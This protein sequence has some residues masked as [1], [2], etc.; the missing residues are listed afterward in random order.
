MK[1]FEAPP[2]WQIQSAVPGEAW[3][4][5]LA[6]GGAAVLALLFQLDRSQ[7]L[8]LDQLRQRQLRQLEVLVRHALATVPYYRERWGADYDPAVP[9]TL[10]RFARLPLLTRRELQEQFESLKSRKVPTGHG[11]INE[12]QSSGSTGTPVRILKTQL[13]GLFWNALTLRDHAWHRRNLR[14]K[15]A[16]IRHGIAAGEF[17]HWG[18]A[19]AG[20][21]ADGPSVVLGVRDSVQTQLRWLEQ[22]QPEYLMT[23]PSIAAELAKLVV[24]GENRLPQLREVRT[25]G[26]QLTPEARELCRE[27]WAVPVTDVYSAEEVGY[28]ALQ[29]PQHEH[30]HIQEEGA[31][32]EILD[33]QDQ[34]CAPGQLGRVVVTTLHNFAMPLIRYELGD[35]AEPGEPCACGRGLAVLRRVAGRVRNMLV[36]AT[37]ERYWPAFGT[38]SF[39]RFAPVRQCQLAQIEY[40]LIEA[41]LVTAAALS[42]EQEDG[43]RGLI[44]SRLPPGFRVRFAY[45]DEIARSAGG[46]YEDFVCEIAAG[47]TGA[48]R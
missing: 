22:Q 13:S 48:S 23:Y 42:V 43:L 37:G 2:F 17:E 28:L 9:L 10:E 20:L 16:T 6:P 29:C 4:A 36:T 45:R 11:G 5:L 32:V 38:R 34:P 27:A 21:V 1:R 47:V 39:T 24:A 41:R 19:T 8:P 40:D 31:L 14:G 25:L 18:Q 33:A 12:S 3:P 46:K 7:W 30:Y 44:Q 15:L 35:Y 26:E